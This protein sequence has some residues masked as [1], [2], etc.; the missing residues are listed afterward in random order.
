MG[1][2]DRTIVY[3]SANRENPEFERRITEALVQNSNGIPIISVTQKPM[4]LGLNICVGDIGHCDENIPKQLFVGA[5]EAKTKWIIWCEADVLY[6]PD[7]F[8]FTPPT[9]TQAYRTNNLWVISKNG[10][11]ASYKGTSDCAQITE[12]EFLLR[13]L[14]LVIVGK[15]KAGIVPMRTWV[16]F[17]TQP[18][19][20]I[21]TGNGLRPRTRT[22]K[23]VEPVA[24]LPYWG[25]IVELKEKYGVNL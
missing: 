23:A 7:F 10:S 9:T 8:E 18:T 16:E 6:P 20:N 2:S 21:K 19:I 1:Y 15:E 3:Y 14:S 11:L 13:R 5:A 17:T 25:N 22:S 4:D 12:R 24:E